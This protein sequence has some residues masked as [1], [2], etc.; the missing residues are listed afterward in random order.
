MIRGT[1]DSQELHQGFHRCDWIGAIPSLSC[2][3]VYILW[4][5]N[6]KRRR[7]GLKFLRR[8]TTRF[9]EPDSRQ[10]L[11]NLIRLKKKKKKKKRMMMMI[12]MKSP[13]KKTVRSSEPDSKQN[14]HNLSRLKKRGGRR[15][16]RRRRGWWWW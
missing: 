8:W 6:K 14:L 2:F 13:E 10:V 3:S 12:M 16:R 4:E 9:S 1:E 15:R 5:N 7:R 11:Q